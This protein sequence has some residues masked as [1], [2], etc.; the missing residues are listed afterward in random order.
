MCPEGTLLH[1]PYS[2]LCI[3]P[4]KCGE[5][6][7]SWQP[8]QVRT[9]PQLCLLSAA[10]TDSSGAPRAHGEVWKASDD[11]CCMYRCDNDTVTPVEYDCSNAPLPECRRAGEVV[12]S[13]ADDTGCCPQ[14]VCGENP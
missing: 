7:S 6:Q 9:P 1:R 3:S 8:R 11:A 10:C 4:E 13:L 12:V 14:K 2:A 5:Q